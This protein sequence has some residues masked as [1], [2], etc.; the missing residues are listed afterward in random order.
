M[1]V[2]LIF[3]PF[4][5]EIVA[6]LEIVKLP[7]LFSISI[8]PSSVLTVDFISELVPFVVIA[9]LPFVFKISPLIILVPLEVLIVVLPFLFINDASCL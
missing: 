7:F 1:P 9:I 3:I 8:A 6:V 4:V 2:F 5:A